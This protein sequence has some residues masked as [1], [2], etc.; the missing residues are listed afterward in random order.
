MTGNAVLSSPIGLLAAIFL[1]A[2]LGHFIPNVSA[3]EPRERAVFARAVTTIR[4]N[5]TCFVDTLQV[6]GTIV[7]KNE[8]LVRTD[9]E[10]LQVSQ[11]LVETGDTV[12]SGQVLARLRQ[13]DGQ[14]NAA[15]VDVQAPTSGVIYA[16]SAV[17]GGVTSPGGQPLFRIA[18]QGDMELLGETPVDSM[19]QIAPDRPAKVEIIGLGEMNGKVRLISTSVNPTTQL[20]Q[21]SI[22]VGDNQG[23]RV[24]VFGRGTIELARRCGPALP[25]S[26]VLYGPGGAIVQIVRNDRV[27]TRPVTVGQIKN[28]EAEIREGLSEGEVAVAR[29]GSFVRDGDRV[30]PVPAP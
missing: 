24:G 16:A 12:T 13:P 4:A 21:V 15:E 6:T 30:L 27:E 7:P 8:V 19:A 3:A 11:I 18:R 1:G 10:G 26:A 2:G 23:L 14:R 9:R 17:I 25:L 28:G 29:A 20:G 22:A 5:R